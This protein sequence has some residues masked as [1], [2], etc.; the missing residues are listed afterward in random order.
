MDENKELRQFNVE[1][2]LSEDKGLIEGC[3]IPFN[4]FSPVREGFRE[5][6]L[7]EAVDGILEQSDI[8]FRYNHQEDK[9]LARCNK[10]KGSLKIDK[11]DDGLYFSFKP[12]KDDLSQYVVERLLDGDLSE[13]S[14]AFVVESDQWTK[15]ADGIYERVIGKFY[16]LYDLSVVDN[17]FYGIENAVTCKRFEE[18]QEEE[19]KAIE[20]AQRKADEEKRQQEEAEKQKQIKDAHDALVAEYGK[21]LLK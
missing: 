21:Y 18:I 10:G 4:T 8:R 12:K 7:P 11:R 2:R 16:R 9:F 5:M 13:M 20:E 17:S 15:N 6:I 14:F 19:R 3:A 1:M